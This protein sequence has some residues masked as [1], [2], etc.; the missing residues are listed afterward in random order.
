MLRIWLLHLGH[1]SSGAGFHCDFPR[2]DVTIF[3]FSDATI[4][5]TDFWEYTGCMECSRGGLH[6]YSGR[7][8]AV[9]G[10][11]GCGS[12]APR[13]QLHASTALIPADKRLM[14]RVKGKSEFPLT[15]PSC[16]LTDGENGDR[17]RARRCLLLLPT[18]QC[19]CE[20]GSCSGNCCDELW[21]SEYKALGY[22][23]RSTSHCRDMTYGRCT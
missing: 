10:L 8:A 16:Q 14:C 23:C 20:L 11:N 13:I 22:R 7:V 5:E 9:P 12:D 3:A 2:R 6:N 21:P 19:S 15:C 17:T 4:D 18:S 1:S